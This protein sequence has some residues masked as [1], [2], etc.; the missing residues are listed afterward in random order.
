MGLFSFFKKDKSAIKNDFTL[1]ELKKGFVVDY[2]M[3]SWEVTKVYLYD[4]GNN[5]FAREY[6][7]DSGDETLY[8]YV[9]DDDGLI[10]SIWNKIDITE[11]EPDLFKMIVANDDAPSQITYKNGIYTKTE[12]SQGHCNEEGEDEE[13]YTELVNWT[14]KNSKEKHFI[15]VSRTG[16]EEFDVSYGEYVKDIEFSNILP[17]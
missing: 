8:L 12:S 16:E 14:Y 17:I 7:L 6:L 9:E 13:T 15:S 2:F 5:F 3:K 4:W 10:C 11:I 1:D